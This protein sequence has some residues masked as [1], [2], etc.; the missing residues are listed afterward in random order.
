MRRGLVALLGALALLVLG[1]PAANA[2]ITVDE[3][4]TQKCHWQNA[5]ALHFKYPGTYIRATAQAEFIQCGNSIKQPFNVLYT[6]TTAQKTCYRVWSVRFE[7]H[8]ADKNEHRKLQDRTV[9]CQPDGFAMRRFPARGV[10][11]LERDQNP[12]YWGVA[13]VNKRGPNLAAL[14]GKPLRP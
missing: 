10:P 7:L 9:R 3:A 2:A 8:A 4:A 1:V 14:A 11:T 13:R 5:Q 6:F 12:R